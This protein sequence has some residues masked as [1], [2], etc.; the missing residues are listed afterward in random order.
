MTKKGLFTDR[1]WHEPPAVISLGYAGVSKNDKIKVLD[2]QLERGFI[3]K[4]RYRERLGEIEE[5]Y[6]NI[7]PDKRI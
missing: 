6:K 3:T 5:K 2:F 4:E 1:R 7:D